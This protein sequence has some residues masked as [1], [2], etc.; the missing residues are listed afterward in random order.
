MVFQGQASQQVYKS[1][2]VWIKDTFK[3]I[4]LQVLSGLFM[5]YTLTQHTGSKCYVRVTNDPLIENN[6]VNY[7]TFLYFL[8]TL[9]T[10][11]SH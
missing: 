10:L 3:M 11:S 9:V 6:T 5:K 1:F 4:C 7:W 2:N 8:Y